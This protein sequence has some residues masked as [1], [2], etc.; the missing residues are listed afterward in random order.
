MEAKLDG[1]SVADSD[2]LGGLFLVGRA[3]VEPEIL[4]LRHLFP[5]LFGE[6]VDRL[7]GDDA[8]DR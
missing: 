1:H 2:D 7:S 6:Q 5:F 4:D 3:D 8:E